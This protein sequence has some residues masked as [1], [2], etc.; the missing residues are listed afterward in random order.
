[1]FVWLGAG[2]ALYR[3]ADSDSLEGAGDQDHA[4]GEGSGLFVTD[5]SGRDWYRD[6]ANLGVR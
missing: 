4:P 6:L 1:M 5:C 2:Q 3:D